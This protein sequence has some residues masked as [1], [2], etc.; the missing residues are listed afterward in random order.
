MSRACYALD[1]GGTKIAAALIDAG[2]AVLAEL[3]RPTE[4]AAG[5]VQVV[6]NMIAA[7]EAL[8]PAAAGLQLAGIGI[9]A[10]GVIDSREARVL[11]AT[12]AMP[13]WAGTDL[14]ALLGSC[15]GLPV[16]AAND[17]HCALLGELARNPL[18]N[19]R[20][21][22]VLMLAVGTGLGG[23]VAFDGRLATGRHGLAG[24][25]GRSL[26]RDPA[27]GALVPLDDLA[28]GSALARHYRRAASG[29][30]AQDG[31]AVMALTAAG[32]RAALAAVEAWLDQLALLLHN[33]H[34]SL[35]PEL[36]LLGG[37]VLDSRTL[38]WDKLLA[39]LD[40]YGAAP[41]LAPA[42]LGN[43]AGLHGA[44]QLVLGEGAAP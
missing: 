3:R 13:G 29:R 8:A 1:V 30:M 9:S 25:F 7:I 31:A 10:A 12:G 41:A 39:R 32:E 26:A 27:D 36:V 2:G 37:G 14:G 35:D 28:S 42:A 33:L 20:R 16:A 21:D 19:G 5:G 44:A 11:D 17:V 23:A 22:T 15:F 43:A 18:L 24:H 40:G 4:A 34:W 38:W 6:R